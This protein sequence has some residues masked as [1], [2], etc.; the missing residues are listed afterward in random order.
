LTI[1]AEIIQ[2]SLRAKRS[3]PQS[4]RRRMTGLSRRM[5]YSKSIIK[6]PRS[7]ERGVLHFVFG[8]STRLHAV[9]L[10][11]PAA[12]WIASPRSQ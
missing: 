1:A 9:D 4:P 12:F 2:P 5:N 11:A 7:L 8:R 10:R 6:T 3:N